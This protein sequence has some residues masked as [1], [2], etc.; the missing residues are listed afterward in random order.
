MTLEQAD[1]RRHLGDDGVELRHVGERH[2]LCP[3]ES[4]G[5]CR[6]RGDLVVPNARRIEPFEPGAQSRRRHE[7]LDAAPERLDTDVAL[8]RIGVDLDTLGITPRGDVE[9]PLGRR[10]GAGKVGNAPV[11]RERKAS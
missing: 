3:L 1:L 8:R 11:W 6:G 4:L 10:G 5:E 2:V 9:Q 7:H